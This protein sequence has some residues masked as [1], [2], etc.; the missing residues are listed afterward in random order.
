[1]PVEN[2]KPAQ[3]IKL[4]SADCYP[5]Y[6]VCLVEGSFMDLKEVEM[7]HK[8]TSVGESKVG[9]IALHWPFILQLQLLYFR[10]S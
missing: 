4:K 8:T 1:M 3:I 7:N 10:M 6:I 2:A 5:T 9:E